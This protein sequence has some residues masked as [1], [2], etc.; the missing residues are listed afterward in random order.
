VENTVDLKGRIVRWVADKNW[1]IIN[2]YPENGIGEAPRKAF[3]HS[4]SVVSVEKPKLGLCVVFNLGP[5]RSPAELPAALKV[6][7]ITSAEAL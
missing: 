6:R 4:S 7:V 5:A 1:G 3:F 2:Y